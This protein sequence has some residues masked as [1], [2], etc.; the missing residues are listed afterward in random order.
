MK[1]N[2]F[3]KS[4]II[5]IIGLLFLIS[6]YSC[7]SKLSPEKATI[8]FWSALAENNLDQAKVYCSS[9]SAPELLSTEPHQL[10]NSRFNYGKIVLDGNQATVETKIEPALN[11]KSSFTTYL[12]KEE[13]DWK[14][15]CE[16]SIKELSGNQFLNEFINNLNTLGNEINKKLEQQLP[17]IEKELQSFGQ[18]LKQQ[19]D[20]LDKELNKPYPGKK[21]PSH[22]ESI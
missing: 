8:L 10:S 12:V 21:N 5:S 2:C 22:P 13:N 7:E 15:E 17:I 18:E 4:P 14:V 20:D 19:L 16:R 11:N 3:I 1:T 9:V 6:I